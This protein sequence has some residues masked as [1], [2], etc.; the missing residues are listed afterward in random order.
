MSKAT[1]NQEIDKKVN[2]M[3]HEEDLQNNYNRLDSYKEP[4]EDNSSSSYSNEKKPT[5]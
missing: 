5:F 1:A 3:V 2:I 4:K